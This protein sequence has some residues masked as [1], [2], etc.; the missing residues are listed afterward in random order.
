[1]LSGFDLSVIHFRGYRI[2][3]VSCYTLPSWTFAFCADFHGHSPDINTRIL[4]LDISES[5]L[6]PLN[7]QT[8][9]PV[10]PALLTKDGPLGFK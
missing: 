2:R 5:S 6:D 8:V 1:M 10:S 7:M 3:Q 9:D 4:S